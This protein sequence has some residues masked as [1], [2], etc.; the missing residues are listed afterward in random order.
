MRL[1][2]RKIEHEQIELDEKLVKRAEGKEE[3]HGAIQWIK[4]WQRR[5][6]PSKSTASS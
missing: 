6:T 5:R 4:Y 3:V 2:G 1:K